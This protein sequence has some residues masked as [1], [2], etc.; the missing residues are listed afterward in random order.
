M[1]ITRLGALVALGAAVACASS[2]PTVTTSEGA[3]LRVD[4]NAQRFTREIDASPQRIAQAAVEVFSERGIPVAN[5]NENLGTVQSLE[6]QVGPEWG[7]TPTSQRINCGTDAT[8]QPVVAKGTTRV[9]LALEAKPAGG[10]SVMTLYASGKHPDSRRDDNT[11]KLP[12]CILTASFAT[13]LLD[14]I[15][16]RAT[17]R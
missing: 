13:E 17:R 7:G 8:G 11:S 15:E 6:F 3:Q 2:N 4:D 10:R 14:A 16:Q 5:A 12:A 9:S 1:V